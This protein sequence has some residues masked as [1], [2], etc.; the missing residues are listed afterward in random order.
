MGV[1][2]TNQLANLDAQAVITNYSKQLRRRAIANDIYTNLRGED[3]IYKR[4]QVPVPDMFYHKVEAQSL[5]GANNVR[6][7]MKEPPNANILL[8]RAVALGTEVAPVIKTTTIYRNNYR[9]VFQAEPGYGEDKLDAAPYRLYQEHVND[10]YPHA[11]AEEG[12]EIR[13]AAVETNGWNLM[14][15]STAAVCPARWNRNVYVCGCP[16]GSQPVYHPTLATYTNRIVAAMN[17]ASGGTGAFRQTIRQMITGNELDNILRWAF[18]RRM[19]PMVKGSRNYYCLTVSQLGAQ[20]FSDPRFVDSMGDRWVLQ[21]QMSN[22]EVQNWNGV[23]GEFKGPN[24][25]IVVAVDDRLPILVPTG[26]AEPFGL[27]ASYVWPTDNDLRELD[28]DLARDAMILHGKGGMIHWDAEAM[29]L[30]Q[31]DWDYRLRNG[32]GYAGVRG[33][34]LLEF[35]T[36]PVD[37]TGAAREHWGSALII[38]GRAEP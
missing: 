8:G 22:K 2:L 5:A 21:G 11:A 36:T 24:A 13:M 35:D 4:D 1:A 12:L 18:R 31:Q 33:I 10:L 19:K 23:L 38:G 37:P 7:V 32:K 30:I 14:A 25:S 26:T 3:I 27:R 17:T 20:R 6:I 29:H 15:G 34:Q 9:I 28:H 16:L